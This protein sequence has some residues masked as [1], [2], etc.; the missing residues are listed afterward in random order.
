[1]E[2]NDVGKGVNLNMYCD[3]LRQS[4]LEEMIL[5]VV[6]YIYMY[7]LSVIPVKRT[8]ENNGA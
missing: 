6:R 7:L 1:M 2:I 3:C 4:S 8:A 5:N